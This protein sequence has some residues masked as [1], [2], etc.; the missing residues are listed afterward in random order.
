MCKS[1]PQSQGQATHLARL[2][3]SAFELRIP[4]QPKLAARQLPAFDQA[5]AF[6]QFQPPLGDVGGD[7]GARQTFER[8]AQ[9]GTGGYF[10]DGG[11]RN[12]SPLKTHF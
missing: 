3:A 11:L 9:A 6:G 4:G 8:L 12:V 5:E 7:A 10:G 1:A 2:S